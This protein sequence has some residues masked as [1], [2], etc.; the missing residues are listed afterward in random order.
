M[1]N[2]SD[3][4]ARSVRLSFRFLGFAFLAVLVAPCEP[5]SE[6]WNIVPGGTSG[7]ITTS[8]TRQSLIDRYGASNVSDQDVDVGEGETQPGTVLFPQDQKRSLDILWSNDTKKAV[9]KDLTINGNSS[10]WHTVH[11]ISLGMSL[12]QLEQINGRPFELSGFGWDYSGT[13]N[14][15][16]GGALDKELSANGRVLL[17]LGASEEDIK[18]AQSEYNRVLGDGVFSSE[19]PEMQKLN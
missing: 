14:S 18:A 1:R 16:K 6:S 19:Q 13:L 11:G 3:N 8:T 15:W 10:L 7:P 17:R 12:K 5:G 4:F 9:P 2:T